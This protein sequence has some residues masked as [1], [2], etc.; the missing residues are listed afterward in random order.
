MCV[1]S[2]FTVVSLTIAVGLGSITTSTYAD[3]IEMNHD[4]HK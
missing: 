1:K 4:D 2:L 3:S